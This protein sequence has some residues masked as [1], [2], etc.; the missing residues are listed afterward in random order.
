MTSSKLGGQLGLLV[1][2][3]AENEIERVERAGCDLSVNGGGRN[4]RLT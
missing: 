3:V 4:H 2:V 1:F